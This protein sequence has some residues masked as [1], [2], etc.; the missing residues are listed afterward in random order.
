MY[1]YVKP[2]IAIFIV[3]IICGIAGGVMAGNRGRSIAAWCILC[4]LFP[5]LLLLIAF[6]KP[7]PPSDKP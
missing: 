7:L 2:G 1:G 3:V 4:A 5:P 6:L